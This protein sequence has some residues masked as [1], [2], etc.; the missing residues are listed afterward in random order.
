MSVL[1]HRFTKPEKVL[2][3][4]TNL[5]H[6]IAK[7]NWHIGNN[8]ETFFVNQTSA[9]HNVQAAVQGDFLIDDKWT[10]EVGG[11]NKDTRQIAGL[12]NAY[13]AADDIETGHD[14]KIPLWLFGF[15]Y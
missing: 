15:L 8:R 9:T 14:R 7:E 10:I 1:V 2:L 13:M 11:K 5:T 6:A 4:N 3:A 12:D